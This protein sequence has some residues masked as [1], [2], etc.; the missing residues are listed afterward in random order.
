MGEGV[1]LRGGMME[2]VRMGVK[3]GCVGMD[4]GERDRGGGGKEGD[5]R[6]EI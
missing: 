6:K 1:N 3:W 5:N 2:G 4:G